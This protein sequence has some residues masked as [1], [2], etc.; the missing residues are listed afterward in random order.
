MRRGSPARERIRCGKSIYARH[1]RKLAAS[2]F[3]LA[4]QSDYCGETAA[5]II[6]MSVLN[7]SAALADRFLAAAVTI[8]S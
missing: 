7:F 5:F 3:R 8:V 1:A 6:G 4:V 2:V